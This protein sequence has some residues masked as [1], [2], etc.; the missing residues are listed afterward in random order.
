MRSGA[1]IVSV[2]DLFMTD[3]NSAVASDTKEDAAFTA[4][5]KAGVASLDAGRAVPCDRVRRGDGVSPALLEGVEGPEVLL[6][7]R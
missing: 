5:V 4:A 2:V 3:T 6:N 7:L 1:T